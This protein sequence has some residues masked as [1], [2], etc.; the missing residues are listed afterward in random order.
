MRSIGRYELGEPI[1]SGGMGTVH[2][3]RLRGDAGFARE[4]AIKCMHPHLAGQ[5]AFRKMFLDE[6]RLVAKI[7]HPNVVQTLD[8]LDDAG[9]LFV[10]ME[11]V[12]GA[13]LSRLVAPEGAPLP[14]APGGAPLPVA[15]GGAPLPIAAAIA[16]GIL[17]GLHA[18]HV[19]K[20]DAGRPLSIVHRD[21]SPDNVLVGTDGVA[22]LLDFGVARARVET[23]TDPGAVKG[24][25]AYLSPERLRGAEAT[26]AS[27]VYAAAVVIW[28]LVTGRRLFDGTTDGHV[29][30][31]I[32]VGWVDPPSRYRPE[33][34][35]A[36]EA[37]LL[38]ALEGDPSRRP[39]SARAFAREIAAA[40][41]PASPPEVAE[42]VEEVA[43]DLLASRRRAHDAAARPPRRRAA[44]A[45]AVAVLFAS[46]AAGALA[47]SRRPPHAT[48]ANAPSPTPPAD[49]AATVAAPAPLPA[50]SVEAVEELEPEA[51]P[52]VV[53]KTETARARSRPSVTSP[54]PHP[55][56]KP[57]RPDC[58]P[59]WTLDALGR[60][61]YKR[62]CLD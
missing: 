26:P 45:I 28:E 62:A 23:R 3:G 34:P 16:V 38:R 47:L 2:F 60:R 21:V 19:A 53:P 54:T 31:Q 6:A 4:V 57:P 5:P 30:E 49:S 40:V 51:P 27:D 9:A 48:D 18:A 56:G 58:T 8:V 29:V 13:P 61:I 10:V 1:A 7:R 52:V 55:G 42:W 22:R 17:E 36:L 44:A 37:T 20:D 39:A 43:R 33:I 14:V 46:V 32:L 25:T 50:A 41:A 11:Y 24:K 15:P 59:P 35:E 12:H